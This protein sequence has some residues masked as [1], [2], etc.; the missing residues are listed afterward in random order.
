[1]TESQNAA[2]DVQGEI[3][4]TVNQSQDALIEVVRDWTD[5]VQAITPKLPAVNVPFADKVPQPEQLVA[6]AYDFAEQLL[7][8]Q[9]RFAEELIRAT[10]PLLPISNETKAET[11][12]A[13]AK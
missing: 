10:S 2:R 7:R 1:M 5:A 3:I 11:H 13:G 6:S 4:K 8:S 9:R 12:K